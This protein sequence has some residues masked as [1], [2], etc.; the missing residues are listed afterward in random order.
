LS[1]HIFRKTYKHHIFS[2]KD[3]SRKERSRNE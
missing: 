1:H 2:L 3:G